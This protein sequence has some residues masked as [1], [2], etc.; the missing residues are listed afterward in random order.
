V[1]GQADDEVNGAV[2]A[3]EAEIGIEVADRGAV[4]FV[5]PRLICRQGMRQKICRKH[6]EICSNDRGERRSWTL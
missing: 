3:T 5:V 6:S 2:F 4:V 1:V